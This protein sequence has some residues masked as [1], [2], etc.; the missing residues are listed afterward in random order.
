MT[1]GWFVVPFN[2]VEGGRKSEFRVKSMGRR[3]MLKEDFVGL[4]QV[5]FTKDNKSNPNRKSIKQSSIPYQYSAT[6][7]LFHLPNMQNPIHLGQKVQ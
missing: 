5:N 3:N 6:N 2:C 7:L 4:G 1:K